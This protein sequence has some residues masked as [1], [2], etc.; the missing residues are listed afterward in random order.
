MDFHENTSYLVIKL[1]THR[2]HTPNQEM[3]SH[4]TRP[5]SLIDT[6]ASNN[7]YRWKMPYANGLTYSHTPNQEMVS[8][9]KRIDNLQ[10]K[11]VFI[12]TCI[13]CSGLS[14]RQS[15]TP[16]TSSGVGGVS[17]ELKYGRPRRSPIATPICHNGSTRTPRKVYKMLLSSKSGIQESHL[18]FI[19]SRMIR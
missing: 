1:L 4:P 5:Y 6:I 18:S 7:C 19:I 11:T 9:L 3:V 8:H 15:A 2:V 14:Q 13:N 12:A 17:Q 10:F 16:M